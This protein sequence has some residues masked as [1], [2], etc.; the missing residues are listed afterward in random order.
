[1]VRGIKVNVEVDPASVMI[2]LY[3]PEHDAPE[4]T[5]GHCYGTSL[6][7]FGHSTTFHLCREAAELLAEQLNAAG[8]RSGINNRQRDTILA[9]LRNYQGTYHRI[10]LTE[11]ATNGGEHT[12]LDAEEIDEL[13]ESLNMEHEK[14]DDDAL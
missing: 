3:H 12:E 5:G 2:T 7:T 9:A 4:M 13:C 11:I 8:F 10:E 6:S 14:G 1:M